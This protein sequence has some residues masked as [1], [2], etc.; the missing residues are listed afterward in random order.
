[1]SKPRN[2]KELEEAH[3]GWVRN[4]HARAGE[5]G[6]EL[7]PVRYGKARELICAIAEGRPAKPDFAFGH[8]VTQVTDAVE[9]S[10]KERGWVRLDEI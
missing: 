7:F 2:F 9:E 1:M 5:A 8:A 10:A 6:I 3:G 4:S